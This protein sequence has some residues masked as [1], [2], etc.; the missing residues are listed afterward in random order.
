MLNIQYDVRLRAVNGNG[1]GQ[2][3]EIS[4]TLPSAAPAP[5]DLTATAGNEQVTLNW[6][7]PSYLDVTGYEYQQESGAWTDVPDSDAETATHTVTGLTNG[8]PQTFR[9]RATGSPGDGSPSNTATATPG[10]PPAPTGLTAVSETEA[11]KLSWTA[12]TP[13]TDMTPI[14]KYEYR[15]TSDLDTAGE[16]VW[17]IDDA[18]ATK[19]KVDWADTETLSRELTLSAV[20]DNAPLTAGTVYYFQVRA[21]TD[22]NGDQADGEVFGAASNTASGAATIVKAKWEFK[23]EAL[24]SDGDVA[25]TLVAGETELKLRFTATYTVG[26]EDSRPTSLWATFGNGYVISAAPSATPQRVGFGSGI[27]VTP[28]ASK[29]LSTSNPPPVCMEELG[30]GTLTCFKDFAG[31]LYATADADLGE[32]A[33]TN[34]VGDEFTVTAM[35]N[36]KASHS[37]TPTASDIANPTLEVTLKP[38]PA[39][40]TTDGVALDGVTGTVYAPVDAGTITATISRSDCNSRIGSRSIRLCMEV[41]RTATTDLS[42]EDASIEMMLNSDAWAA[43]RYRD[44]NFTFHRRSDD[45]SPWAAVPKCATDD[46]VECYSVTAPSADN[47]NVGVVEVKNIAS[48]GQ[49]ALARRVAEPNAP[50]TKVG[51]IPEQIVMLGSNSTLDVGEFFRDPDNDRLRYQPSSSDPTVVTASVSGNT[52]VF[53]MV[54]PGATTMTIIAIDPTGGTAFQSFAITVQPANVAPEAEDTIQDQVVGAVPLSIDIDS[55][56][57]D[58]DGDNLTYTA[59]SDNVEAITVDMTGSMLTMT[60][61]AAGE[62]TVTIVGTDRFDETATQTASVRAN[63]PPEAVGSIQNPGHEG[64]R[65]LAGSRR[66]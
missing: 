53:N 36:G 32:Y 47:D 27:G 28:V 65:G 20:G 44:S 15:F 35:V 29:T 61:V 11:I 19:T 33:L 10:A 23:I 1:N 13:Y 25:T 17:A 46:K 41:T 55:Y 62:S 42:R 6:T 5:T 52:V 50:P 56:F 26:T 30:A 9:V 21:V 22:L 57:S 64:R 38:T 63:T 4:V 34:S 59:E 16:P 43:L 40:P 49:F 66:K 14:I 18:T 24:D 2:A 58:A 12:P 3:A 48:F 37:A 7:A 60:W 45:S 39:T 54:R 31:K 8:D 51:T